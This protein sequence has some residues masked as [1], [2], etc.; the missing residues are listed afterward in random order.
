MKLKHSSDVSQCQERNHIV[1]TGGNQITKQAPCFRGFILT[2]GISVNAPTRPCTSYGQ[3]RHECY[4]RDDGSSHYACFIKARIADDDH[5]SSPAIGCASTRQSAASAALP[6]LFR[7]SQEGRSA[8]RRKHAHHSAQGIKRVAY[9]QN[10][11][12]LGRVFCRL[13]G[14]ARRRRMVAAA[15]AGTPGGVCQQQRPNRSHRSR[16]CQ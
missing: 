5:I 1:V 7:P 9:G 4:Y 2:V 6:P 14:G 8:R 12:T 16:Y 3:H 13:T 10:K 11:E 15:P